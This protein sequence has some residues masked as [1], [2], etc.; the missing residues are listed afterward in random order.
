MFT[1][2]DFILKSFSYVDDCWIT[3]AMSSQESFQMKLFFQ[4][5]RQKKFLYTSICIAAAACIVSLSL[6][7][8]IVYKNGQNQPMQ[9]ELETQFESESESEPNSNP[10]TEL[11]FSNEPSF[12]TAG[13]NFTLFSNGIQISRDFTSIIYGYSGNLLLLD[14]NQK[15][16][17]CSAIESLSLTSTSDEELSNYQNLVGAYL[18][19]FD[20]GIT[21]SFTDE[22][23][24]YTNSNQPAVSTLYRLTGSDEFSTIRNLLE[25]LSQ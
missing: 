2:D 22:Y 6:F 23:F 19:E 20:N 12:E 18:L 3:E 5:E 24:C 14:P 9:P 15:D 8:S 13:N 21:C 4:K 7:L 17:L 11:D 16:R 10:S 1:V 25:E